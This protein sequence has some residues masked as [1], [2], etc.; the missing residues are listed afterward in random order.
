MVSRTERSIN[1]GFHFLLWPPAPKMIPPGHRTQRVFD[2]VTIP[3]PMSLLCA[4][5]IHRIVKIT[6]H[7]LL[8]AS[9]LLVFYR[10][11]RTV[12]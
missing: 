3:C 6:E 12:K 2:A 4:D 8:G 10:P 9:A 7:A 1:E 11:T 5:L